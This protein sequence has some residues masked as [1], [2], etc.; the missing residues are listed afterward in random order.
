MNKVY[1]HGK[2]VW[3]IRDLVLLIERSSAPPA[4]KICLSAQDTSAIL[5]WRYPFFMLV[6]F[7]NANAS[8]GLRM[9]TTF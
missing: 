2:W 5:S 9:L 1:G 4:M 6:R 8:L 3:Q 7:V